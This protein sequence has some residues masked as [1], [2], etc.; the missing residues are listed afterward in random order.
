MS[1]WLRDVDGTGSMHPCAKGD[2]G[3]IEYVPAI[4][5]TPVPSKVQGENNG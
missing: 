5:A 2:P 4:A 1:I 3:A